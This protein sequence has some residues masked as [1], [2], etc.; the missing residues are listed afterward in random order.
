MTDTPRDL[1]TLKQAAARFIVT[2]PLLCGEIDFVH[3]LA[4]GDVVSIDIQD[5]FVTLDGKISARLIEFISL[6]RSL[7]T[8]SRS[9]AKSG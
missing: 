2:D 4:G 6:L 3:A 5:L 7:V 8:S 1:S 9:S